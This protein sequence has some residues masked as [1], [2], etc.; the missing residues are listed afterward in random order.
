MKN[1][2]TLLRSHITYT[3]ELQQMAFTHLI[4]NVPLGT[5]GMWYF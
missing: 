1:G 4:K 3:W 5:L 2:E